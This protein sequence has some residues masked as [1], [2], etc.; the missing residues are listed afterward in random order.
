MGNKKTLII[1]LIVITLI[2]VV[3]IRLMTKKIV[4]KNEVGIDDSKKQYPPQE[5][6][7]SAWGT[8]T[9]STILDWGTGTGDYDYGNLIFF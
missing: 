6:N 4:V 2:A 1:A 3:V 5:G 8:G 7:I 9:G